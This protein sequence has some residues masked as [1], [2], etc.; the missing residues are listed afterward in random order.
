MPPKIN[1][2][3]SS[4]DDDVLSRIVSLAELP[5]DG[6][7]MLIYGHSGTGKTRMI[8]SFHEAGPL[9]HMICSSNKTNEARS[10]RGISG[11]DVVEIKDPDDVSKLVRYAEKKGY[12]TVALD[13]LTEFGNLVLAKILKV[14][15]LPEQAS[16]GLASQQQY[17]QM[18]LQV[19]EHLRNLLD[20][21]GNVLI[22]GQQRTYDMTEDSEGNP[23]LPYVSVAT[24]PAVAG[25]VTPACDYIVNTFKQREQIVSNKK[26]GDK[27]KQ[28]V[29][30]GQV[31]YFARTGPSEIYVTK[32]RVP[33]GT[34]IPDSIMNPTYANMKYLLEA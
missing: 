16:W 4:L 23:L 18:S 7:K 17:Q 12:A 25:W 14:D 11:I 33:P 8:G 24:T 34:D 27:I 29:T 2:Q 6:I 20:F 3:A 13:H 1:K 32:F 31:Q 28:T 10:I 9:L 26:I 21:S 30:P 19:K 5:Y 22:A 15:K